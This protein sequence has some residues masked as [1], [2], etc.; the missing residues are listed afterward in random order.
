M[1]NLQVLLENQ[2]MFGVKSLKLREAGMEQPT[3]SK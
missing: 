1:I 3:I 2:A